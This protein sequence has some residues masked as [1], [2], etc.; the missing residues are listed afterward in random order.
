MSSESISSPYRNYFETIFNN[1]QVNAVLTMQPD[2]VILSIN[3][4]FNSAFGYSAANVEGRNFS[5]LFTFEDQQRGLP[6]KELAQA[7]STGQ[8]TDKNYLVKKNK[9]AVWVSGETLRVKNEKGDTILLK[10]FQDISEQKKSELAARQA[11]D[12]NES[13]LNTID[14]IVIALNK[15]LTIIKAN[16][17]FYSLFNRNIPSIPLTDFVALVI[18][19]DRKGELLKYIT[20]LVDTGET[21][22]DLELEIATLN[23]DRIFNITGRHMHTPNGKDGIL[24]VIHEITLQKQAERERE[25]IIGF[26]AHELR[27]PLSNI[28]LCN[29]MLKHMVHS[30]EFSGQEAESLL[31]RSQNNIFRLNK[32]IGE[33]YEA[34]KINSGNFL[35]EITEFDFDEMIRESIDTVQVVQPAFNILTEGSAGMVKGD[36]YRLIQVVTNYLSNGIKYSNGNTNVKI[37]IS[38][39]GNMVTVAVQDKGLGI[40]SNQLPYIFDRFFRAEKTKN[41]EGIGLGLFLCRRIIDAHHGKVWAESEEGKGSVFYFSIPAL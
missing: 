23:G 34:T 28:I 31:Q 16:P 32:M 13:I 5:L 2:G 6:A 38:K 18:S 9:Q 14:D 36:R 1:S 24:L 7:L 37:N 33:L 26:V 39:N 30:G 4:A 3:P 11:N 27:N 15:D 20:R 17:A 40:P 19:Y 12:F 29:E 21:F 8:A 41:L 10:I 22:T 25:D 35:L